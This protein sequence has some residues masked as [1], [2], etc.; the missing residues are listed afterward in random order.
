MAFLNGHLLIAVPDLIDP[1]FF[2]SAV[3]LFQHSEDGAAGLVLN[4]PL[5]TSLQETCPDWKVP[6]EGIPVFW[7]GPVPGPLMALHG[8]LTLG[9]IPVLPGVFLSIQKTNLEQL[10]KQQIHP[11]RLFT[12]YSGW[13]A[14]QL[15][16][17][18]TGGGWLTWPACVD[19]VFSDVETLWRELCQTITEEV[20]VPGQRHSRMSHDPSWN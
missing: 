12:G 16:S 7:G 4:R 19:H 14:H 5:T 18:L 10:V 8:S 17:E 20:T 9:E 2:R 15:E 13:G 6:Q 3:L 1:N 11:F